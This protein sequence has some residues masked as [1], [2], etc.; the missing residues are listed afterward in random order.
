MTDRPNFFARSGVRARTEHDRADLHRLFPGI[1]D[2]AKA[3]ACA[4][5]IAG[6]RPVPMTKVTRLHP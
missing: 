5:S 3:R 1:T 6:W 4:R 2:T